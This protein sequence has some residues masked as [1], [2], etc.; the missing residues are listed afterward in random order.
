M[1]RNVLSAAADAGGLKTRFFAEPLAALSR[2]ASSLVPGGKMLLLADA[3]VSAVLARVR[4][5]FAGFRPFCVALGEEDRAEGLF[6]LPDDVRLA[7]AF[8]R[9]SIAAARFFCT[10]RGA[11]LIAV[12]ASLY[13]EGIFSAEAEGGYPA[14][15][16]DVLLF[17]ETF[18]AGRGRAACVASAAL[19]ALY[20]AD[21]DIDAAFSGERKCGRDD[22]RLAA[23]FAK[24]REDGARFS[25]SALQEIALRRFSR[26]PSLALFRLLMRGGRRVGE[27]AFAA[28]VYSAETY[29]ALFSR[30]RIRRFF[31]P[32]Y[33]ARVQSAAALAGGDAFE[34]VRVPTA[35]ES[36][37]RAGLFEECRGHF[38]V[39]S[40][41]LRSYAG[42]I[43]DAYYLA[44]GRKP[45]V[46]EEE[47]R[48]AFMRSADL[49]PLLSAGALARDLGAESALP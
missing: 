3:D 36:F 44:G 8:G 11:F 43:R 32:D 26:F 39:E 29:S 9:R 14:D 5:S 18:V 20:A 19:S 12:P 6:S 42:E 37:A 16:P 17:D 23:E 33:G 21:L 13:A 49:S 34:N 41:L 7:V 46:R 40:E 45:V 30:A 22:F 4:G 47:L 35:E 31:V 1:C 27:S 48:R 28:L 2:L 15:E 10:L 25:A 24:K 38:A